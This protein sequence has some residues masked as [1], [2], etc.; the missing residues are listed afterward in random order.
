MHVVSLVLIVTQL[1]KTL[2]AHEGENALGRFLKNYQHFPQAAVSF[3]DRTVLGVQPLDDVGVQKIPYSERNTDSR[4]EIL[5]A[6]IFSDII[7]D[8]ILDAA[9]DLCNQLRG[10][11][12]FSSVHNAPPLTDDLIIGF[13]R[14][15]VKHFISR[16]FDNT[17]RV[18]NISIKVLIFFPILILSPCPN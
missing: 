10:K 2:F 14:E 11:R 9:N 3:C 4:L 8:S 12:D 13:L 5:M 16:V 15:N 6:D 1:C 17:A 18:I 7:A